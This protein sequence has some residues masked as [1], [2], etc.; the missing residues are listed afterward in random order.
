[1]MP[2]HSSSHTNTE[3]LFGDVTKLVLSPGRVLQEIWTNAPVR[4]EVGG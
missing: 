1:M 4:Y 2:L 3:L